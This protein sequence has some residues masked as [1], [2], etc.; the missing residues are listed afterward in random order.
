MYRYLKCTGSFNR[1]HSDGLASLGRPH[2]DGLTRTAP[3]GRRHSDGLDSLDRTPSDGLTRKASLGRPHW[4]GLTRTASLGQPHGTVLLSPLWQ[5]WSRSPAARLVSVP[6]GEAVP[7]GTVPR[8]LSPQGR[9]LSRSPAAR[10]DPV[11][12]GKAVPHS[13]TG[14][15]AGFLQAWSPVVSSFQSPLAGFLA[16]STATAESC[17]LLT[18]P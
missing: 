8:L 3:L 13:P 17:F 18:R 7:H 9:G 10:F 12:S 15:A 14:P 16:Q 6:S 11:P 2:W 4:T 5:G 1:P